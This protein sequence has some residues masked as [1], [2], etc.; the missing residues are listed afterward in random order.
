MSKKL[1]T[2]CVAIF[3]TVTVTS[4]VFAETGKSVDDWISK[5]KENPNGLSSN[6][7]MLA[8]LERGAQ[9]M[10]RYMKMMSAARID[11]KANGKDHLYYQAFMEGR[12]RV[13]QEKWLNGEKLSAEELKYIW[14]VKVNFAEKMNYFHAFAGRK[15]VW[16]KDAYKGVMTEDEM[17]QTL[18]K[19]KDIY[20]KW[21]EEGKEVLR[22][23]Y[24]GEKLT[25][26]DIEKLRNYRL[27]TWLYHWRDYGVSV[28]GKKP[29]EYPHTTNMSTPF[30][31]GVKI[32]EFNLR[33]F[34]DVLKSPSFNAMESGLDFADG[35]KPSGILFLLKMIQSYKNHGDLNK[36]DVRSLMREFDDKKTNEQYYKLSNYIGKKIVVLVCID[37]IDPIGHRMIAPLEVLHQAYKKDVEIIFVQCFYHDYNTRMT[38]FGTDVPEHPRNYADSARMIQNAL[39][40]TPNVS[41]KFAVDDVGQS[42]AN[43]IQSLGGGQECVIIDKNGKVASKVNF[44]SQLIPDGKEYGQ[45]W[46]WDEMQWQNLVEM[47]LQRLLKNDGKITNSGSVVAE[48]KKDALLKAN[49]IKTYKDENQQCGYR[50]W[51]SGSGAGQVMWVIGEITEKNSNKKL[52]TVKMPPFNKSKYLGYLSSINAEG[53]INERSSCIW[54]AWRDK[55]LSIM[56]K[57]V[58]GTDADRTYV[59]KLSDEVEIYLNGKLTTYSELKV[60]ET[61]GVKYGVTMEMVVDADSPHFDDKHY[62]PAYTHKTAR[63]FTYTKPEQ[64]RLSRLP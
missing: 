10:Y 51:E 36:I 29:I 9:P 21:G 19:Y 58:N 22:K 17:N 26:S 50:R 53:K 37:V 49:D 23:G 15:S 32:E 28:Y 20:D 33:R 60:G 62:I 16:F 56:N 18:D 25:S 61:I 57:W 43:A 1:L 40:I 55:N 12:G 31:Y 24:R 52:I 48:L 41:Y 63:G 5:I 7:K 64:V 13:I 27:W 54:R 2:C 45:S 34:D 6:D 46:Y 11:R 44:R 30:E 42:C 14:V 39:M 35:A 47:E 38:L 59:F 8:M 4:A 3:A